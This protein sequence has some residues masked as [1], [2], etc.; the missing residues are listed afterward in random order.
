MVFLVAGICLLYIL[1]GDGIAH[2]HKPPAV[3][4][5]NKEIAAAVDFERD[6]ITTDISVRSGILAVYTLCSGCQIK[7]L[8]VGT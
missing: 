8:G 1:H 5:L 7:N 6:W 3:R 2:M 4:I